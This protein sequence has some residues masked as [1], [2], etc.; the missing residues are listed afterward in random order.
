M[1]QVRLSA[2]TSCHPT[3]RPSTGTSG[4]GN[5]MRLSI[6]E[7]PKVYFDNLHTKC[8]FCHAAWDTCARYNCVPQDISTMYHSEESNKA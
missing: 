6:F 1:V 3:Q 2:H 8:L 7:H 5:N 4:V